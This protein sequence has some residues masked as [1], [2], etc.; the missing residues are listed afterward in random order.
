MLSLLLGHVLMVIGYSP[1]HVGG[2]LRWEGV[3]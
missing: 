3:Q 1:V 2:A